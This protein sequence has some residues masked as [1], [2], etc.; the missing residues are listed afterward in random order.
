MSHA[1]TIELEP[2]QRLPEPLAMRMDELPWDELTR[3]RA[4]RFIGHVTMGEVVVEPVEEAP[5]V[6]LLESLRRA[7]Q[8][9]QEARDSGKM[10]VRTAVVE[11]LIKAGIIIPIETE[12]NEQG[13]RQQHGQTM[14]NVNANALVGKVA[15]THDGMMSITESETVNEHRHD[16]AFRAGMLDDHYMLISSLVPEEHEVP[17]EVA[18]QEA[19]YFGETMSLSFQL[20][21]SGGQDSRVESAFVAGI[22]G[23]ELPRHDIE[24]LRHMYIAAGF[25]A[26]NWQPIDFHRTP[27]LI[28]KSRLEHGVASVVEVYDAFASQI[29]GEKLFFGQVGAT[30]SYETIADDSARRIAELSDLVEKVFDELLQHL[31]EMTVDSD[32]TEILTELIRIYG[33][34][35]AVENKS[36]DPSVLGPVAAENIYLARELNGTGDTQLAQIAIEAAKATAIVTM[37]GMTRKLSESLEEVMQNI[38]DLDAY[39]KKKA[40]QADEVELPDYITCVNKD[41][42]KV[43]PKDRVVFS[44]RWECPH[45]RYAVDI[46]TSKEIVRLQQIFARAFLGTNKSKIAA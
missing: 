20:I 1:A 9:D 32:A 23:E 21:D 27:L 13:G 31:P 5:N 38:T 16:D 12:I 44:D 33:T 7:E 43:S 41:C 35:H 45:C 18:T 37:C 42:R 24:T 10:N 19:G 8:G 11:A 4:E 2:I 28:P 22:A 25:D 34:E 40:E 46:C 39:R 14:S 15:R 17:F 26:H 30:G 29:T 36:I 6:S 3:A